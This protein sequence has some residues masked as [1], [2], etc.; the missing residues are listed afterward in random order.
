VTLE[1]VIFEKSTLPGGLFLDLAVIAKV[2][3]LVA[4]V[5]VFVT[6][7]KSLDESLNPISYAE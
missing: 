3:T 5:N 1:T 6:S 2:F 4:S 7:L